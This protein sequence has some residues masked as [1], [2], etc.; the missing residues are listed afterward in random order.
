MKQIQKDHVALIIKYT[1]ISF[2]TWALSHWF[3][4]WERQII[5]CIIWVVLFIIWTLLEQK[6]EERDYMRTIML[7]SVFAI[8]I[9]ALTWGLQHFPDSPDRSVWLVPAWFLVSILAYL[10]LEKE[11]VCKKAHLIYTW[12]GFLFFV[13]VSALLYTLVW[14]WYLWAWEHGHGS[15][16]HHSWGHTIIHEESVEH[17][18]SH[19]SESVEKNDIES[20]SDTTDVEED[21]ET[22]SKWDGHTDHSH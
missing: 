13:G 2:I 6:P 17:S 16:D 1:W 4:S 9:W 10:A 15:D 22:H 19:H 7:S 12:I 14:A 5:I 20:H 21:S 11:E 3:F 18:P 8:S